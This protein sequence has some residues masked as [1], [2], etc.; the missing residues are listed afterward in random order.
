MINAATLTVALPKVWV[1]FSNVQMLN[2]R[3]DAGKHSAVSWRLL[4][5]L[6]P[7]KLWQKPPLFHFQWIQTLTQK[8]VKPQGIYCR[9]ICYCPHSVTALHGSRSSPTPTGITVSSGV[10]ARKEQSNR[11]QG[12]WDDLFSFVWRILPEHRYSAKSYIQNKYHRQQGQSAFM[13]AAL[14]WCT[15]HH[16]SICTYAQVSK[17]LQGTP[18]NQ[19]TKPWQAA[20]LLLL[21]WVFLKKGC[22]S[23]HHIWWYAGLWLTVPTRTAGWGNADNPQLQIACSCS[24]LQPPCFNVQDK[25]GLQLFGILHDY[26]PY[27]FKSIKYC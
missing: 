2:F 24:F 18:K 12:S 8:H 3:E 19:D 22:I 21:G 1:H 11:K 27:D 15:L 26:C 13:N 9:Y 17:K 10:S 16:G 7:H 14:P 20:F 5:S 23:F 25:P 6:S 4:T